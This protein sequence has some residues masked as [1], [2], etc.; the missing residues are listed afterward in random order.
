M[1]TWEVYDVTSPFDHRKLKSEANTKERSI[2]LARPFDRQHHTFG[3]AL[4]KPARNE[5]TAGE[6]MKPF[7]AIKT[8][9]KLLCANNSSPRIVIVFRIGLL[10]LWFHIR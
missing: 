9:K 5:D 10:L 6:D 3:A 7:Y 8:N 4:T 1:R 2:L